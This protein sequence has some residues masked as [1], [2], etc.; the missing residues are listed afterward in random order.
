M[1]LHPRIPPSRSLGCGNLRAEDV[2]GT[3]CAKIVMTVLKANPLGYLL[4]TFCWMTSRSLPRPYP[5]GTRAF[6]PR[7]DALTTFFDR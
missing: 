5:A 6:Y 1:R 3:R 4:D 7:N 2:T